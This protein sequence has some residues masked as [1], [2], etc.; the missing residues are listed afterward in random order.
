MD[1]LRNTHCSIS[2]RGKISGSKGLK[3]LRNFP[4]IK[5]QLVLINALLMFAY[6]KLHL[7][8]KGNFTF[9]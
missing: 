2:T 3:K 6:K 8:V 1:S 4:L 9:H 7:L 5:K